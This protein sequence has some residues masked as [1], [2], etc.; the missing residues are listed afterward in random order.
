[1][2]PFCSPRR[3]RENV[4][5]TRASEKKKQKMPVCNIQTGI[6]RLFRCSV[7]LFHSQN[8]PVIRQSLTQ[9]RNMAIPQRYRHVLTCKPLYSSFSCLWHGDAAAYFLF[10]CASAP[11]LQMKRHAKSCGSNTD[12]RKPQ[13][14]IVVIPCLRVVWTVVLWLFRFRWFIRLRWFIWL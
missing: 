8:I 2:F 4:C 9:K 1:M 7:S 3:T 12:Q 13:N 10:V 14:K 11:L 6:K 5:Q